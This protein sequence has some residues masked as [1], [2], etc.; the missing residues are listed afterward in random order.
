VE[1][2]WLAERLEAGASIEAIAREVHRH[3]SSV[4]YWVHK[5]GLS[6]SHTERHA[7]RGPID[8]ELLTEIVR[9]ELSIRDM[10]DVLER[11]PTTV[12][13]W[14]RRH[15]LESGPTRRRAAVAAADRDGIGELE[16]PCDRHGPT[17]HVRRLDG[18]RARDARPSASSHGG[19][20]SS[21]SC[22]RRPAEPA[23]SAAT[24]TALPPCSSIM[25]TRARSR[26]L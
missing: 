17:R 19:A 26:S 2:E 11:S 15:G 12:R 16:L 3:P 20:R 23:S 21:G 9:C 13:H 4:A 25:L 6:S 8:R 5:H 18:F 22:S 7:A 10:A 24:R 14:L 1:R